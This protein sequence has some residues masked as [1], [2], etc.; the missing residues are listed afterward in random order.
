MDFVHPLSLHCTEWH[1]NKV[2]RSFLSVQARATG[3]VLTILKLHLVSWM[4]IG[5]TAIKYK[6]LILP[7][8]DF[9]LSSTTSELKLCYNRCSVG[10]SVSV[11]STHLVPKIRFLLLSDSCGFGWLLNC[12]WLLP[13]QWFLV[14]SP[15]GLMTIFYCLTAL[16]AFWPCRSSLGFVDCWRGSRYIALAWTA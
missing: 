9:S 15:T 11:S 5:L 16:G 13:T 14:L 3:Y 1:V 12:C 8:P 6:Y 2:Y 4:V 10:Q 7:M